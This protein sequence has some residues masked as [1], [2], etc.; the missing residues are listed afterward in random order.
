MSAAFYWRSSYWRLSRAFW[1]FQHTQVFG[2]FGD[3]LFELLNLPAQLSDFAPQII[4]RRHRHREHERK[5]RCHD[6]TSQTKWKL[7]SLLKLNITVQ[8]SRFGFLLCHGTTEFTETPNKA[9]YFVVRSF[10]VSV[11]KGEQRTGR[12][13]RGI[14]FQRNHLLLLKPSVSS[15]APCCRRSALPS[16]PSGRAWR[17]TGCSSACGA[18]SA[19]AGRG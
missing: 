12:L 18:G 6:F 19:R 2:Q 10:R 17:G 3:L 1:C 13:P 4:L 9:P 14:Q 5:E 7:I 11:M 8:L 16:R 15:A